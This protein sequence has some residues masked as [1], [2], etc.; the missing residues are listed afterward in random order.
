MVTL[1]SFRELCRSQTPPATPA[2]FARF[3][4]LSAPFAS[5]SSSHDPDAHHPRARAT[6]CRAG[7]FPRTPD[8]SRHT[9]PRPPPAVGAPHVSPARCEHF[10]GAP[11]LHRPREPRLDRSAATV[12]LLC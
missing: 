6:L 2:S 9:P 5:F 12:G 8:R 3:R 4:L 1:S 10:H 7:P 11:S